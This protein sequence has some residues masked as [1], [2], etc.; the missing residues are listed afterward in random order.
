[1]PRVRFTIVLL[2]LTILPWLAHA[3]STF[4]TI[5][6]TVNDATG[7]VLP[8]VEIRALHKTLG[9]DYKTVSNEVGVF[10][11]PELREGEYTVRATKAGFKEFIAAEINLVSRALRRVDIRM[12]LGTLTEKVE[13]TAEVTAI[14]TERATVSTTRSQQELNKLP[15]SAQSLY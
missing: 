2:T 10:T 6:G 9:L 11:L 5:T 15:I 14:K 12:A 8:G 1:M 7:A 13:V 4:A 3:Q